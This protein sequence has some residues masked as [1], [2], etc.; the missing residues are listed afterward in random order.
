MSDRDGI[1]KCIRV[2]GDETASI[3]PGCEE[4]LA[5]IGLNAKYAWQAGNEAE[6]MHLSQALPHST[7]CA[8]V[9]NTHHNPVWE[10]SR[11]ESHELLS[12]FKRNS[13]F[14]FNQ[15]GI[16]GAVAVVPAELRAG[17]HTQLP[18]L[19]V[20]ALHGKYLRS[21]DIGRASCRER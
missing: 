18:C 11:R 9:P 5:S 7:N 10:T 1:S 13:L 6:D 20:G 14:D 17:L 12:E 4:G 8:A 15:V 19:V 16:D 3:S 21:E 2:A